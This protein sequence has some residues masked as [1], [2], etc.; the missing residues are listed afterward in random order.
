MT[1]KHLV[2]IVNPKSGADRKKEVR[3]AIAEHL[4]REKYTFEIRDTEYAK[5][6]TILAREAAE[7][8][9]FA[10]VA[11][12]G[13]GSV[14][15]IIQGLKGHNTTLAIIP[16]GSGNGMA[17]TMGI[18]LDIGGAVKV[19]NTG[20]TMAVD[21]G[22]AND[23]AFISNS[24]VAFDALIA[25]KFA[26]SKRRGLMMYSWLITKYLWRYKCWYWDITVDGQTIREQAFVLNVANGRQYGYNFQIAPMA[27]YTDGLLDLI[28]VR[29]FPKILGGM[30]AVRG[31]TGTIGGS[32]YLKHYR[33][34]QIKV[35]NPA[36]NL[37]QTDGDAHHC[38]NEINFSVVPGGLTIMT[39]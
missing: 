20:K 3:L 28:V 9:A 15:D 21:L 10:V 29:K 25:K 34:R 35:T 13:D 7:R 26:K 37:F 12:G 19:I 24:G 30:L 5:H 18:P 2:F 17:R 27:D 11:V 36:L 23:T 22:F 8:G 31:L 39:P 38:E 6:G 16:K 14:N 1:K 4:D 33:G 32:P